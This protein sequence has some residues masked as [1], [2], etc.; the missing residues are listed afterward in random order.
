[1]FSLAVNSIRFTEHKVDAKIQIRAFKILLVTLS[2]FF[3]QVSEIYEQ[4]HQSM[5]QTPIK[6]NVPLLWATMSQVKTNHYRS[7]AH[8]FVASALL[9]HQCKE[10]SLQS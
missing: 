5:I 2:L 4:V 7:M 8:Y 6:D 10:K 9:D 3:C 1:M